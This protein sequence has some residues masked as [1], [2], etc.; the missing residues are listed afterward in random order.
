MA[1]ESREFEASENFCLFDVLLLATLVGVWL[2]V[3]LENTVNKSKK[4]KECQKAGYEVGS[5]FD[6]KA[7]GTHV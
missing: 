1:D 2:D 3:L 7:H 6:L 5:I 4:W